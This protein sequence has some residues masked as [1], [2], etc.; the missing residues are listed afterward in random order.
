MELVGLAG[1]LFDRRIAWV[2]VDWVRVG[3][4]HGAP[5]TIN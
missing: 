4:G 3:Y 5:S 2:F 1:V